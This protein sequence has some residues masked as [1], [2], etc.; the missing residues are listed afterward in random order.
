MNS[1]NYLSTL[2]THNEFSSKMLTKNPN[3]FLSEMPMNNNVPPEKDKEK[4]ILKKLPLEMAQIENSRRNTTLETESP[5][6]QVITTQMVWPKNSSQAAINAKVFLKKYSE[7]EAKSRRLKFLANRKPKKTEYS[8][9]VVQRAKDQYV[10]RLAE[11]NLKL[12]RNMN[13]LFGA[14]QGKPRMKTDQS[15]IVHNDIK[16]GKE[17]RSNSMASKKED[18]TVS[19]FGRSDIFI[20]VET[21]M[22]DEGTTDTSFHTIGNDDRRNKGTITNYSFDLKMTESPN[23]FRKFSAMKKSLAGQ[24]NKNK[25]ID[26]INRDYKLKHPSNNFISIDSG[27]QSKFDLSQSFGPRFD[28][29]AYRFSGPINQRLASVHQERTSLNT[30]TINLMTKLIKNGAMRDQTQNYNYIPGIRGRSVEKGKRSSS[31]AS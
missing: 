29:T 25:T 18:F 2:T 15:I 7:T 3:S 10:N 4:Q 27:Y 16:R 21:S 28:Q 14:F 12:F 8:P 5:T 24:N 22:L 9:V 20:P 13:D 26:F 6:R 1:I 23:K 17:Y 31:L 30:N 19:K 11:T